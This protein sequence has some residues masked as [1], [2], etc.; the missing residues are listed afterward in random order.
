MDVIVELVNRAHKAIERH[1]FSVDE[2]RIGRAYDNDLIL[3]EVHVCPH[4]AV[5][6]EDEAG[7]WWLHDT[8]STNG[9][10]SRRGNRLESPVEVE[11]GKEYVLGKVHL[12]F[13]SQDH[14][15]A[16]AVSLGM[17]DNLISTMSR[18]WQFVFFA[19]FAM[20][21]VSG[22]E[23]VN[24]YNV[25][26][27]REFI[28]QIIKGPFFAFLW[29]SV[30]AIT[31]RILRHEPRF[32]AQFVI[33]LSY[34]LLTNAAEAFI[35]TVAFNSGDSDLTTLVGYLTHGWLMV[36]LLSFNLRVATQQQARARFL[37]ANLVSWSLVGLVWLFSVF[38][39]PSFNAAP[40]Y[41]GALK[42]PYSRWAEAVSV[43]TYIQDAERLFVIE[44][45]QSDE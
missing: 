25:I 42:P 16:P 3:S 34:L 13:Y 15:V 23:Y 30:W 40:E 35:Q 38:S 37:T 33:S 41:V 29:A 6:R 27:A 5:L 19:I 10:L 11:T 14:P 9:I 44:E 39:R 2:C 32:I 1:R 36:L 18:P 31:G 43:D 12:K 28:P 45:Q 7:R 4:H 17:S 20:L 24:S 26:N 8:G 22:Y 21:A